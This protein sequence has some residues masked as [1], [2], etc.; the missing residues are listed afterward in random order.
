MK[1][2]YNRIPRRERAASFGGR[3]GTALRLAGQFGLSLVYLGLARARGGSGVAMH[4]RAVRFLGKAALRGPA[5][6]RDRAL[7]A[8]PSPLDSVRYFELEFVWRHAASQRGRYLDVSSPRLFPLCLLDACPEIQADLINPDSR[9]LE[10]TRE[11]AT[12][13]GLAARCTLHA[14]TVEQLEFRPGSFNLV[15]SISVLEHIP[16][17]GDSEAAGRLWSFVRPGGRLVMTVP[18]AREGLDEYLDFDEYGLAPRSAD[19]WSFGQRLYDAV[20]LRDAYFGVL[21]EPSAMEVFGEL[22]PGTFVED[23]AAKAAGRARPWR[24]PL[25]VATDYGRFSSVDALPGWG[26]AGLVFVKPP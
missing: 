4:A 15:T 12:A 14:R 6:A 3:A 13:A 1:R 17:P 7:T 26:V 10:M 18:V 9:D 16:A 22:R 21:G 23:R 11:L 5:G 24:E 8:M 25:A 19:G 20:A 2:V